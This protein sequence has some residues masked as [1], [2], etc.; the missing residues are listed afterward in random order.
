LLLSGAAVFP[1]GALFVARPVLA[2]AVLGRGTTILVV[3]AVLVSAASR[4][5]PFTAAPLA[6]AGA[7]VV[8]LGPLVG[9]VA[10][11]PF[12]RAGTAGD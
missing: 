2:A 1:V 10:V 7:L 11:R 4:F 5:P 12:R 3:T 8:A 6:G 9:L